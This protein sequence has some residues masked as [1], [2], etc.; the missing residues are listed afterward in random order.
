[1]ENIDRNI[2]LNNAYLWY[3]NKLHSHKYCAI[4]I[5]KLIEKLLG[6]SNILYN[7]ITNRVKTENSF[8][9]KCK[10]DKYMKPECEIMDVVGIRIITYTNREVKQICELIR[11]EFE[12]DNCN[13]V[14]K[15]EKLESDKVGYLSIHYVAKINE[16]RGRL[17][18]YAD[19]KDIWFEIQIRT[20][21]QHTWAEIEHDKSYKFSGELRKD[22]KRRFHLIAGVLELV[23]QEF[24]NL[25]NEIDLYAAD[26]K[27]KTM[28]GNFDIAIDSTSLQEYMMNKYGDRDNS[29][30]N[31]IDKRIVDELKIM[32][33][34]TLS[35]IEKI[36]D[37]R[38]IVQEGNTYFGILRDLMIIYDVKKYF[39]EA[40][41]NWVVTYGDKDLY[42]SY[43]VNIMEFVD[44]DDLI[45]EE[46][47]NYEFF[48]DDY[49][50]EN[51]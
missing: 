48:E 35:D 44:E 30:G 31:F 43:G 20:L 28:G 45:D 39:S 51:D 14:N 6:H 42:E 25:S 13:S 23:D 29:L 33:L 15:A 22:L 37:P 46:E 19:I 50:R 26:V 34:T 3:T 8:M 21:L 38:Y 36:I 7:S 41:N 27:D 4:E 17:P 18:E 49:N 2:K 12:I 40:Y 32:G 16:I 1:M 11:S 5:H 10:K 9:E 24:E 47:M